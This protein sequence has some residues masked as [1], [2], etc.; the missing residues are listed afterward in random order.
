MSAD[1]R[2]DLLGR[3]G[4]ELG[5]HDYVIAFGEV[6]QGPADELLAGPA[7]VSDGRVEEVDPQVQSVFDDL[8]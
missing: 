7:L 1:A 5:G 6:P 8:S 2:L 4:Q 3:A